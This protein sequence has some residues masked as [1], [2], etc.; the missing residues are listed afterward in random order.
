MLSVDF[1]YTDRID[2]SYLHLRILLFRPTTVI[3]AKSA[4]FDP[5]RNAE[6][7]AFQ[8]MTARACVS[9]CVLAAQELIRILWT[10]TNSGRLGPWWYSVFCTPF[11]PHA[12]SQ[13]ILD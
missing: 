13:Q 5:A 9:A 1:I 4:V 11:P 10:E 8:R 6:F 3:L 12:S 7:S 2:T